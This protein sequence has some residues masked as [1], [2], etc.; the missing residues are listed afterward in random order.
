MPLGQ[1][2]VYL[3][4]CMLINPQHVHIEQRAC[5]CW[6]YS[7]HCWKPAKKLRNSQLQLRNEPQVSSASPNTNCSFQVAIAS[8]SYKRVCKNYTGKVSLGHQLISG[9]NNKIISASRSSEVSLLNHFFRFLLV[10]FMGLGLIFDDK[11]FS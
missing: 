10:D 1:T 4:S 9:R 2:I 6:N 5:S 7:E 11:S 8:L 3:V